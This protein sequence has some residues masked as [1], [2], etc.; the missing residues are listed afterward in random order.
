MQKLTPR[1]SRI[2]FWSE[3]IIII[4]LAVLIENY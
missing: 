2:L 3:F 4:I 1:Q